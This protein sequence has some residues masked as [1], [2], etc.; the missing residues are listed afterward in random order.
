M[1]ALLRFL[2]RLGPIF[3]F[4]LLEGICLYLIV[5]YNDTQGRI[6]MSSANRVTGTFSNSV[7]K[8]RNYIGLKEENQMLVEEII[9]LRQKLGNAYYDNT[10]SI[11]T[12]L[13]DSS[14]LPLYTYIDAE[15]INNSINLANNYLTLN[16]GKEHGIR[17]HMGVIASNGIVGIVRRVSPHYSS[18]MSVLHSRTRITADIRNK[19]YFGALVWRQQDPRFMYLEDV[20]KHHFVELGDTVQTSRFSRIFPEGI[21]IGVVEDF[22]VPEGASN[23]EIKVRLNTDMGRLRKVLVVNNLM[24]QEIEQL[25]EQTINE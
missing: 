19:G 6:F 8:V 10:V 18:V 1:R 4:L 17:P 23:Y 7:A 22:R 3:L 2:T 12:A 9:E 14:A 24:S 15:V 16:K 21:E 13:A 20:P 11:D 5:T 25:E